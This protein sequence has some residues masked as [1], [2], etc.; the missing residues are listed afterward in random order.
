MSKRHITVSEAVYRALDNPAVDKPV[1]FEGPGHCGNCRT[2]TAVAPAHRI[3]TSQFGSWDHIVADEHGNR[4]LCA[5]CAWAYRAADYR[6]R[7]TIITTT[8]HLTHPEA[9][10]L[11]TIL[12]RPIPADTA[13]IVPTSAKKIVLPR[14]RWGTLTHDAGTL[15]WTPRHRAAI[16][17]AARLREL[18]C[19]ESDL[20][21]TSPPFRVLSAH[22]PDT[23]AEIAA[24]WRTLAPMRRDAL[25]MPLIQYLSRKAKKK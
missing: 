10:Q 11:R 17:A 19:S 2:V 21:Q 7:S 1:S 15:T 4:W 20:T 25:L 9:H 3:L 22:P 8:G 13:V 24:L 14:G 23:Q 5:P 6:R 16:N 12:Q 18:G